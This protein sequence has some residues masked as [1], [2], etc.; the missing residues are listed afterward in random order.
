MT[1]TKHVNRGG[2]MVG[3]EYD[4]RVCDRDSDIPTFRDNYVGF[5]SVLPLGP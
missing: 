1:G 2:G 3:A 5:R 4:C